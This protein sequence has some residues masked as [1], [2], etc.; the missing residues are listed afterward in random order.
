MRKTV[1]YIIIVVITALLFNACFIPYAKTTGVVVS[2]SHITGVQCINPD[3]SLGKLEIDKT[4]TVEFTVLG[5]PYRMSHYQKYKEDCPEYYNKFRDD[6]IEV[7]YNPIFPFIN[8]FG[9]STQGERI[10]VD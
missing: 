3:G 10:V 8:R 6:K 7:Y 9:A 1:K 4:I 5:I 2:E